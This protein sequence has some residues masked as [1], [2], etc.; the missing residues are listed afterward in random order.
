VELQ[1]KMLEK[2]GITT[3]SDV[4]WLD[5]ACGTC[6]LLI[7]VP[8]KNNCFVSTYEAGDVNICRAN[9]FNNVEQFDFLAND[10]M[11]EFMFQ[12]ERK[13]IRDIL[14]TINKP[15]VVVMNPPYEKNKAFLFLDKI[16]KNIKKFTCFWYCSNS[17]IKKKDK[18]SAWLNHKF[19][20]LDAALVNANIFGLTTWGLLMSVLQYG[21]KT[22]P[23]LSDFKMKVWETKQKSNKWE[24]IDAIEKPLI[25]KEL[26]LYLDTVKKKIKENENGVELH[27]MGL[28]GIFYFDNGKKDYKITENNLAISLIAAGTVWNSDIK[29]HDEI[30]YCPLDNEGN[31]RE[32]DDQMK[33]DSILL[34]MCY[35]SNKAK[36]G[37][38]LFTEAELGLPPHTLKAMKNGQMFHEWFATYK[39]NLSEEGKELYNKMLDVYKFYLQHFGVN[40][41]KNVG[42]DELKLSFMQGKVNATAEK[43]TFDTS[44]TGNNNGSRVGEN[45]VWNYKSADRKYQTKLFSA[46]DAALV[47]LMTKQYHR[48]IAYGMIDAMP[49]C[50]R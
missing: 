11:P 3:E 4:V 18:R 13:N 23:K 29:W 43:R 21:T 15:V 38:S 16:Q 35:K 44:I 9:G 20:V 24:L 6:N 46:Y 28:K 10:K 34:A 27:K 7:D 26:P 42:L 36:E 49:S 47:K 1:W 40:A 19:Q 31:V 12:G 14:K 37:F 2:Q 32:F 5:F 39:E 22:T 30:V 25:Y 45:S 41:N 50:V 33:A 8:N 17:D 48:F